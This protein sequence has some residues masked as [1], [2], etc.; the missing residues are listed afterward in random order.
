[1]PRITQG[2]E[3]V[4]KKEV[5]RVV[6]GIC[7]DGPNRFPDTH[8]NHAGV[9]VNPGQIRPAHRPVLIEQKPRAIDLA[10]VVELLRTLQVADCFVDPALLLLEQRGVK[11]SRRIIRVQ[12]LGQFDFFVRAPVVTCVAEGLANQVLTDQVLDDHGQQLRLV[13]C[14]IRLNLRIGHGGKHHALHLSGVETSG[15]SRPAP[16]VECCEQVLKP[17]TLLHL[18]LKGRLIG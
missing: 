13:E 17:I 18:D 2:V 16:E 7:A 8:I 9:L 10:V 4:S 1:M 12:L 11:P 6:R 3:T 14:A 5:R 15:G